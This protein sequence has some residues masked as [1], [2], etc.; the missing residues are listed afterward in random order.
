MSLSTFINSKAK[1][2]IVFLFSLISLGVFVFSTYFATFVFPKWYG[3]VAGI[4]LMIIAIPFHYMGKKNVWGYFCA[5]IINSIANGFTIS[6]LKF[7]HN[8]SNIYIMLL[9]AIPSAAILFLVYLMLQIFNKT[10]AVTVT[11]ACI[12]NA[13]LITSLIVL[14]IR[15][16]DFIFK[17][18][19]FCSLISWC[20]LGVF[21]VTIN[22]SERP[23]FRDLSFGSFGTFVILIVVVIFILSEGEILDGLDFDFGGGNGK[24][25]K[26]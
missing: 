25:K 7:L 3:V 6:A 26:K 24:H 18:G 5:F 8:G 2:F 10:K 9:A 22:H 14:I 20:Y 23:V 19:V 15:Y 13:I 11:V 17:Y 21:G 12:I 16:G 4:V 1:A